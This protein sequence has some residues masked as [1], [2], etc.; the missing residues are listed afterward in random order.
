MSDGM[1]LIRPDRPEDLNTSGAAVTDGHLISLD[2]DRHLTGAVAPL[3]HSFHVLT[4]LFDIDVVMLLVGRP[5]PI[6]I[7]SARLP[8]YDQLLSHD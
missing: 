6:G 5:G 4:I 2:D 8:V 3:Q 7:R 1:L